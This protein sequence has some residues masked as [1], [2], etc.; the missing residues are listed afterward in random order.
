MLTVDSKVVQ[1]LRSKRQAPPLTGRAR[2]I[3]DHCPPYS[4]A[5]HV[6]LHAVANERRHRD[7]TVLDLRVAQEADRR[8]LALVPELTASEVQ[9]VPVPLFQRS[10]PLLPFVP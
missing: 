1:Y 4:S 8:L 6:G 5:A 7:A 3:L 9:R 10:P 2:R